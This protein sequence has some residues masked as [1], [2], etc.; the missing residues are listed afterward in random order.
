[1]DEYHHQL[2]GCVRQR[3]MIAMALVLKT[4]L[5]IATNRH[6]SGCD[7]FWAVRLQLLRKLNGTGISVLLITMFWV[8]ADICRPRG[9]HLR[10][11]VVESAEVKELFANPRLPFYQRN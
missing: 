2:S 6:S 3:V 7:N 5:L 4:R 11:Q 10:R 1:L 9:C 8:F